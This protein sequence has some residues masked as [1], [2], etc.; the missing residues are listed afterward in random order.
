MR[1]FGAGDVWHDGERFAEDAGVCHD[2]TDTKGLEAIAQVRDLRAL[3]VEG[4]DDENGG[5]D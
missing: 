4:A 5:Q 1:H 3:G 2:R